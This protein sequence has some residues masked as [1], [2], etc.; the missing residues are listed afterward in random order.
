MLMVFIYN[1]TSR[2]FRIISLELSPAIIILNNYLINSLLIIFY[3]YN[4][5]FIR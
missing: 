3:C 2:G 1:I 5:W 4:I